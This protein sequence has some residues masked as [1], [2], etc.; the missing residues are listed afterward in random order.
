MI[1]DKCILKKV[2]RSGHLLLTAY[3]HLCVTKTTACLE[4]HLVI[5]KTSDNL[6]AHLTALKENVRIHFL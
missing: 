5:F 4:D 1:N 6:M 3:N 2:Y